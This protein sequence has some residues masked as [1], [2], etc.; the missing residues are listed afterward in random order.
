MFRCGD[1]VCAD[2]ASQTQ[3]HAQR[4]ISVYSTRTVLEIEYDMEYDLAM[5]VSEE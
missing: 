1:R 2:C 5:C 3:G 4:S